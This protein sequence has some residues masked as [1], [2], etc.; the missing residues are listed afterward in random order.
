MEPSPRLNVNIQISSICEHM[1]H[2]TLSKSYFAY[3][4][5]G[6]YC[7][8]ILS[9]MRGISEHSRELGNEFQVCISN[10]EK[11]YDT[12]YNIQ[13][14]W[15]LYASYNSDNNIK[16]KTIH[17]EHTCAGIVEMNK[18]ANKLSWL[19]RVVPKHIF[20]LQKLQKRK[21]LLIVFV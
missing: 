12:Q 18:L 16:I 14:S 20:L 11:R 6:T 17:R 10:Y 4:K 15:L 5:Y 13:C 7:Q 21:I 19:R 3:I 8:T 9:F 1:Q 2:P